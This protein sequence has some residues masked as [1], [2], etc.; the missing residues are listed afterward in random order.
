MFLTKKEIK[1]YMDCFFFFFTP[2]LP[3]EFI[4]YHAINFLSKINYQNFCVF[5]FCWSNYKKINLIIKLLELFFFNHRPYLKEEKK[6]LSFS[7]SEYLK[8][9]NN[10]DLEQWYMRPCLRHK[11]GRLGLQLKDFSGKIGTCSFWIM[12]LIRVRLLHL[13]KP[14]EVRHRKYQPRD[15][16]SNSQILAVCNRCKWKDL[17]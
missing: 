9:L 3:L 11:C 8:Q 6:T 15:I 13:D 12:D 14:P 16:C 2:Q 1:C 17:P 5:L 10:F 7:W 4:I